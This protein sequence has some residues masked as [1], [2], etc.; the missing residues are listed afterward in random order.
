MSFGELLREDK[1]LFTRGTVAILLPIVL[2]AAVLRLI[3]FGQSPPGLNQD[4]AVNAW[5]A[6]SL[7]KTGTDQ[8]GVS[9]PIF[10]YRGLGGNGDTLYLYLLLPFQA[11]GGLNVTTTR[12]PVTV[13]GILAIPL[14]YF[15]GARLF[16]RKVGLLAAALLA[17]DPWHLQ[18]TRW[19]HEA[20]LCPFFG[21]LCLA[22]MLWAN[23]PL[24]DNLTGPPK[25]L[26]AGL[27]GAAAGIVCYGYFAIRIFVP[28]F[29]FAVVMAT[30]PAWRRFVKT[31]KGLLSAAAFV[32]AFGLIFGP[33]VWQYIFHPEGI[34][35]HNTFVLT[36][37]SG[38]G[39]PVILKNAVMRY[40]DHFGLGFLFINGDPRSFQSPPNMGMFY[41]YVLPLMLAGLVFAMLRFRKSLSVRFLLV[42]VLVYPVSDS[43]APHYGLH[44]LRSSPGLCAIVLL[45]AFGAAATARWLYEKNHALTWGIVTIFIIAA[46]F[47]NVRYLRYFYGGYNRD[48]YI[49]MTFHTDLL[50][51]CE[52]FRSRCDDYDAVFC[53]TYNFNMPYVITLVALNYDPHRWFSEPR[54]FF[55]SKEWDYYTHYGK[56]Y[57]MYNDSFQPVLDALQQIPDR[58]PIL[59][60]VR[61][62]ELGLTDPIYRITDPTGK[63]CLWLCE[64]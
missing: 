11:I 64:L 3:Y 30:I 9:L 8:Y 37:W 22:M 56:M 61:P 39:W 4:E 63:D 54:E 12:L 20:S 1:A 46:A 36:E 34:A 33:M 16:N 50:E 27:A 44:S 40:I 29:L 49:Y 57:F 18:L 6:W 51:A 47:L 32:L 24:V 26:R 13:G 7:L 10:Y 60:I 19:G 31:R 41:W 58:K 43:L 52:W 45:G 14:I 53:T 5:T 2:V 59:F 21:L 23:F 62:G 35:R 48:P 28:V 42:F 55:S 25:P 17:F 15:V 38:A